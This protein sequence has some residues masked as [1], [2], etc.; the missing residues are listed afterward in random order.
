MAYI[1]GLDIGVASCGWAVTDMNHKR[2]VDF[3]VRI[4]DKA[5]NPKTGESLN[6]PRREARSQRRRLERRSERLR[7]IREEFLKQNMFASLEEMEQYFAHIREANDSVW[8]LRAGGLDRLLSPEDWSRVLIRIA[9]RR[10]YQSNRRLESSVVEA[11]KKKEMGIVAERIQALIHDKITGGFRTVGETLA[12]HEHYHEYKRNRHSQHRFHIDR[13]LLIEEVEQLFEAQRRFGSAYAS[14]EFEELYKDLAFKQRPFAT[15]ELLLK[16]VGGCTF[17]ESEGEKRAAKH[18][19]SAELFMLLQKLNHTRLNDGGFIRSLTQEEIATIFDLAHAQREVK[20]NTIRK[21]LKLS[22]SVRFV[23]LMYSG[24]KNSTNLNDDVKQTENAKFVSLKFYHDMKNILDKLSETELWNRLNLEREL[25]DHL[26]QVLTL[27]KNDFELEEELGALDISE[28]TIEALKSFSYSGF[29]HLSLRAYDRILPF[30]Q[31]GMTYDK[32]CE[33]AG[34]DF[35][36]Q[37]FQKQKFLPVIDKD[38]IRNPVVL[39]ALSQARKVLNAMVREYGTPESVHI[40]VARELS[41]S[42]DERNKIKKSIESNRSEKEKLSRLLQDTFPV[43]KYKAPKPFDL[44]KYRLFK[45]QHGQ[46]I[47]SG[48]RIDPERLFEDGYVEVDHILPMS[49]T[50]DDSYLNKVLVLQSENRNKRNRTPYEWIGHDEL[51]WSEFRARIG[52]LPYKKQQNLLRKSLN[53]EQKKE[54]LQRNLNDTRYIARYF[55]NFVRNFLQIES[56]KVICV[57]G[58]LTSFLRTRFGLGHLKNRSEDAHHAL[59][60][61]IVTVANEAAIKRITDFHK[62]GELAAL[63]N[64]DRWIDPETGEIVDVQFLHSEWKEKFP[65]P[66]P[67]FRTEV[68]CRFG[69]DKRNVTDAER[70]HEPRALIEQFSLSNYIGLSDQEWKWVRP[71]FVSRAPNRKA[72]GK[73]HQDTI[74][75]IRRMEASD[76]KVKKTTLDA[77]VGNSKTMS[78]DEARKKVESIFGNDPNL[79]NAVFKWLTQSVNLQEDIGQERYPRKV[80]KNGIGPIIRSVKIIE[81]SMAGVRMRGGRA[82]AENDSMVRVD[83]FER[84]GRYYVVPI[85]VADTVKPELPNRAAKA[86]KDEK[87]W[88]LIDDSYSFKFS[89]FKNDLVELVVTNK[90]IFAYYDGFHRGTALFN[91]MSHDRSEGKKGR[92]EGVGAKT[93]VIKF[94]K[95]TVDPLGY[96]Y[97]VKGEKR[98]GFSKRQIQQ[99][100]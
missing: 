68:L 44:L 70:L 77:L 61:I 94:Q 2:I 100:D 75:G 95:Y 33:E 16:K 19:R 96:Y 20:Y 12:R 65:L 56:G 5:E 80:A 54:F 60:A 85:Y 17:L 22:E 18:T 72:S 7:L 53:E 74:K 48:K 64:T 24:K 51:R 40:E 78:E 47:Y 21:T 3:G 42:F 67:D 59:D 28:Q 4:F 38:D 99:T 57:N 73:A 41:K 87:D 69:I 35:R 14:K 23:G 52:I 71:L 25:F 29:T 50:M 6:K 8:E 26:G 89:L 93:G 49:R 36:V 63:T 55:S 1:F 79:K 27:C 83:V 82:I 34:F 31:Q 66:W 88:D 62:R 90:R 39:R 86:H 30:L 91:F 13:S 15:K 32:A 92:I 10:G 45:E 81:H 58:Q 11:D 37:S 43:F 97:P 98:L 46:C 84:E 76:V 9:K